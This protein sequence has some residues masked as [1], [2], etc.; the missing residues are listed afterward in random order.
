MEDLQNN[1]TLSTEAD[2]PILHRPH[3]RNAH[4]DDSGNP[5][6]GCLLHLYDTPKS[7][8]P[9]LEVASS[10]HI[11]SS[12]IPNSIYTPLKDWQTR[13]L[14]VQSGASGQP[15]VTQLLPVDL[16]Y[17]EG[18]IITETHTKILYE[19]I[20]YSWGYPHLSSWIQCN[21]GDFPV[22]DTVFEVLQQLRH[23][24]KCRYL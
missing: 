11:K 10:S 4:T 22:S 3:Q 21:G 18:V 12:E 14:C 20:S 6:E 7:A 13:I 2:A 24:D 19:A 1:P 8:V 5:T 23:T 15:L 9:S 16:I 17:F